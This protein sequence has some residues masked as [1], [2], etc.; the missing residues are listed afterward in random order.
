[1]AAKSFKVSFGTVVRRIVSHNH[2][3]THLVKWNVTKVI[4]EHFLGPFLIL[5]RQGRMPLSRM[6]FLAQNIE[7][8]CTEYLRGTKR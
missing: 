2:H 4:S 3:E 6:S 8:D 7:Q 1:M 5:L